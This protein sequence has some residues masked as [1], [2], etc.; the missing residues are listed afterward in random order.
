VSVASSRVTSAACPMTRYRLQ[1]DVESGSFRPVGLLDGASL[2]RSGVLWRAVVLVDPGD[3][4][5][6][7][8]GVASTGVVEVSG[9]VDEGGGWEA[10]AGCPLLPGV[11]CVELPARGGERAVVAVE[12]AAEPLADPGLRSEVVSFSAQS[13]APVEKRMGVTGKLVDR[14]LGGC[15][16]VGGGD[17]RLSCGS[18]VEASC[19]GEFSFGHLVASLGVAEITGGFRD[20]AVVGCASCFEVGELSGEIVDVSLALAIA[21][22]V[23]VALGAGGGVVVAGAAVE[24]FEPVGDLTARC[25]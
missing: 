19:A 13:V 22:L 25:Q 2:G 8:V 1:A 16:V 20:G 6:R 15:H 23:D 4:G 10:L 21:F 12:A 9:G 17:D 7:E 5:L 14:R 3:Q 11:E 18:A 24:V